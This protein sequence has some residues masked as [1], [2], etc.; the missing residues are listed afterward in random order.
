MDE[1]LDGRPYIEGSKAWAEQVNRQL[2][3]RKKNILEDPDAFA[4]IFYNVLEERGAIIVEKATL[5]KELE[6]AIRRTYDRGYA[7]GSFRWWKIWR[8]L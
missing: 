8:W 5:E 4:E 6:D 2:G 1:P 7:D 3:D